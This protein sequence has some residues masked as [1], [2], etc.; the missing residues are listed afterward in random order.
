MADRAYNTV[1]RKE[2][3][4]V[5]AMAAKANGDEFDYVCADEECQAVMHMRKGIT[6]NFYCSRNTPHRE[7]CPFASYSKS[8]S[9]P[10][11]SVLEWLEE[12]IVKPDLPKEHQ[13][14]KQN[15]SAGIY[16]PVRLSHTA[17]AMYFYQRAKELDEYLDETNT[18][19]VLDFCISPRTAYYYENDPAKIRGWHFIIGKIK[20][21]MFNGDYIILHVFTKGEKPYYL[22]FKIKFPHDMCRDIYDDICKKIENTN[23]TNQE[24]CVL[25]KLE[26]KE[27]KYEYAEGKAYKTLYT[28]SV[29]KR[30]LYFIP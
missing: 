8:D 4:I 2:E 23:V 21:L 15:S 5:Q 9:K 29:L 19:S 27:E 25:C 30:R 13:Q 17:R 16:K 7:G 12:L 10:P 6:P 22:R 1:L 18:K 3:S 20:T 11:K 14:D 26:S 24:L 28:G